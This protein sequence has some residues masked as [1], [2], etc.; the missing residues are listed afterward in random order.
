MRHLLPTL[1][2]LTR[3]DMQIYDEFTVQEHILPHPYSDSDINVA[4]PVFV[5]SGTGSAYLYCPSLDQPNSLD[6]KGLSFTSSVTATEADS[7]SI[8]P[9]FLVPVPLISSS[10][11]L[12]QV[13]PLF[14]KS[15]VLMIKNDRDEWA[16]Y[17]TAYD[18][19]N[20]IHQAYR[21]MEAYLET[22]LETAGSALSLIDE[23]AKVAYWTSGAR[24][25]F[26][27]AK[28]ISSVSL[29]LT[30]PTRKTS[31]AENVIHR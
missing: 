22:T 15:S 6:E 19:M 16:G 4:R 2:Q 28:P 31:I 17:V 13:I 21:L 1:K 23:E 27:F 29:L 5:R 20:S 10:M 30:F 11:Q 9:P 8:T 24:I 25:S 3:T 12:A 7:L 26:L 18:V 14:S